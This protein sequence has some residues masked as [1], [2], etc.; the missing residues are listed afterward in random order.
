MQIEQ[1][2]MLRYGYFSINLTNHAITSSIST[3]YNL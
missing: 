3:N 2:F 1:G